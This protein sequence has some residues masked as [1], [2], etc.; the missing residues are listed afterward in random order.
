M[1]CEMPPCVAAEAIPL[2]HGRM[3]GTPYSREGVRCPPTGSE[4]PHH[5]G[6]FA[7]PRVGRAVSW[8]SWRRCHHRCPRHV[9]TRQAACGRHGLRAWAEPGM[10]A[11]PHALKVPVGTALP[12]GD[13]RR[14]PPGESANYINVMMLYASFAAVPR[15]P[16]G[17]P[18][19]P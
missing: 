3:A 13:G 2:E 10:L 19:R 16:P 1:M 7:Q 4:V 14:A 11:A 5:P 8:L 12:A 15:V 9:G 6:V 17:G 18:A